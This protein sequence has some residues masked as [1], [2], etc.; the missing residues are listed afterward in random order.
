MCLAGLA[1]RN[2]PPQPLATSRK[3]GRHRLCWDPVLAVLNRDPYAQGDRVTVA[4]EPCPSP[5]AG[6][7][8]SF[9]L[10]VTLFP[11][12]WN[13]RERKQMEVTFRVAVC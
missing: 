11:S 8:V 4:R 9:L 7:C 1:V 6:S 13:T 10:A 12:T 3:V 2:Q 5:G